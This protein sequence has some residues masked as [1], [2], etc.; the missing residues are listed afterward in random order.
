MTTKQIKN[1]HPYGCFSDLA[2][3]E[4]F[5]IQKKLI[6]KKIASRPKK[7]VIL[8]QPKKNYRYSK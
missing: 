4:E 5:V 1:Y 6:T 2:A 7:E 8:I 3:A